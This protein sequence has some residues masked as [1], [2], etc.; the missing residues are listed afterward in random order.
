M[1]ENFTNFTSNGRLKIYEENFHTL[2]DRVCNHSVMIQR[3]S[4]S[5]T[6]QGFKEI[7]E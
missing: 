3:C 2:M 4:I 5:G 7:Y 1:C 6:S